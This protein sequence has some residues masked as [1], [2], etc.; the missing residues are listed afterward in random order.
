MAETYSSRACASIVRSYLKYYFQNI[1]DVFVHNI[2]SVSVLREKYCALI[3][4]ERDCRKLG[5]LIEC[6]VV[7]SFKAVIGHLERINRRPVHFLTAV[8][9]YLEVYVFPVALKFSLLPRLGVIAA[10]GGKK[11]VAVNIVSVGLHVRLFEVFNKVHNV[12]CIWNFAVRIQLIDRCYYHD[13]LPFMFL[14][15]LS[16]NSVRI[17]IAKLCI[18][19]AELQKLIMRALFGNSAVFEHNYIIRLHNSRKPVSNDYHGAVF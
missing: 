10:D 5:T 18:N 7:A 12:L 3:A 14:L 6:D 8:E 19:S 4:A 11:V 17:N 2:R 1:V 15:H 9:N 13:N 16:L